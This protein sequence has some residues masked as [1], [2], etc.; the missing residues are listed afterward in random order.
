[1]VVVVAVAPLAVP[2]SAAL[3]QAGRPPATATITP[4]TAEPA[5]KRLAATAPAKEN[6]VLERLAAETKPRF[7]V[8]PLELRAAFLRER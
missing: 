3:K 4:P 8:V 6:L 2:R 5:L 7:R 1:M